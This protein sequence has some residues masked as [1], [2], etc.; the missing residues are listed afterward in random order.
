MNTPIVEPTTDR[1]TVY[2]FEI[3]PDRVLILDNDTG[4]LTG[5]HECEIVEQQLL[6]PSEF[7]VVQALFKEHPYYCPYEVV[8]SAMTGKSVEKCRERVYWG[9][10]N[11][12][13]DVVM[14]PVRNLLGRCRMKLK[15]F[16]LQVRSMVHE[17]Y[18]LVPVKAGAHHV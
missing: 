5:L 11:N 18:M 13:L 2:T 10:E 6:S 15:P 7:T 8:L 9:M 14:R 4:V 17:G 3:L 12:A 16:G 1:F